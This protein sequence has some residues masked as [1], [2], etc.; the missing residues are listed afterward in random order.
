M[1][2]LYGYIAT[3]AA[4]FCL[5]ILK[6]IFSQSQ[7]LLRCC[8]LKCVRQARQCELKGVLDHRCTASRITESE[9]NP[10]FVSAQLI[11]HTVQQSPLPEHKVFLQVEV[12][13]VSSGDR[14]FGVSER[15]FSCPTRSNPQN[16]V[17]LI[18]CLVAEVNFVHSHNQRRF[19][20]EIKS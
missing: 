17:L 4:P 15:A 9:I 19:D 8:R 6:T 10:S 18:Y 13:E 5:H 16:F 1:S 7:L 14:R 3:L 2:R 11:T 20:I 12:E